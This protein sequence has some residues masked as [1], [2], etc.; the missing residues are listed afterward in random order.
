VIHTHPRTDVD[1]PSFLGRLD[2]IWEILP[3]N[4]D[5][6]AFAGNGWLGATL[7]SDGP[8]RLRFEIGRCDVTEH[9]RDNNRLP[10]GRL[11]VTTTGDI[12]D[13]RLRI[14][15]WNGEITGGV[16]TSAGGFRLR[17]VVHA[18]AQAVLLDLEVDDREAPVVTW[19]QGHGQDKRN[20]DKIP[21]DPPNPPAFTKTISGLPVA[22][23]P[24]FAGGEYAT[25][26]TETR[27]G[28]A[29]RIVLSVADSFPDH[30]ARHRVVEQVEAT[31]A[32]SFDPDLKEHRAW[33]HA[34]H[35]RSFVSIPDHTLESFYWIQ[36]YKFASA[37]RPDAGPVDLLGPWFRETNWPRVWWNMN[38]E[39]LY[40]PAF[41]AN[42]LGLA[43]S[44]IR[45]IDAKRD[46]FRANAK[47]LY[48]IENGAG[49]GHTTCREGLLGDGS[50]F[51]RKFLSPGDFIW[52]LHLYWLYYRHTMDHTLVTDRRTHAFHDLLRDATNVFLHLMEEGNDGK[53][54]LPV[55]H[56]PEYGD[57][58]DTTYNL[59]LFRWACTTLLDL[60]KRYGFTEPLAPRWQEVLDRLAP[61][62]TDANGFRIGADCAVENSHRHWSHLLMAHPLHT[63]DLDRAE[64][65]NTLHRSIQHWLTVG[66][67]T[68][69]YAWSQSGAASLYA[70]L[71]DGSEALACLH[72]HMND[73]RFVRPNTMYIEQFPVIE[74]SII[75]ARSVQD[76]LL[77]SHGG[78]LRIFP[79]VPD[80][81]PDA[82]FHNFRAE[83]GFLVSARREGGRTRWIRI[84]SE[85]GE[86]CRLRAP[87]ARPF[88]ATMPVREIAPGIFELAIGANGEALLHEK[89]R[90]PVMDLGP[91]L[92]ADTE[93]NPWGLKRMDQ[94]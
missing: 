88:H 31:A 46:N 69:I 53:L 87:F 32:P 15:L 64:N 8:R 16:T 56:S 33:W 60:A 90:P 43:E 25:A 24:R 59:A 52:A 55:L 42:Q 10:V 76:M 36:M 18:L 67:S 14:D 22:I 84:Y 65:R 44:F 5:D 81:W 37:T 6:G 4:P 94:P 61:Y 92:R 71:G 93:R 68:G 13:G 50:W 41:T 86:P 75:V 91:L 77:R 17:G 19:E 2:P 38:I 28:N 45:F 27:H 23:Q 48:G 80:A 9:R 82:I 78:T 3:A 21:D 89:E 73:A 1:W 26:W 72:R 70:A 63:L 83:G 57:A 30:T 12:T 7:Y 62:A 11:V 35:P 34:F 66:G 39:C 20:R 74:C 79:A 58:R 51:Q 29:R 54:H 47:V 49:V 40:L 85:A